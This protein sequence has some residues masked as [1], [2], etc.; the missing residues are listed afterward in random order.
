[1]NEQN[2]LAIITGATGGLGK[3]F[4]IQLA[5]QKYNL[6]LSGRQEDKL[7]EIAGQLEHKF[8]I[9]AEPLIADLSNPEGIKILTDKIETTE[10]IDMLVSNAGYGERNKFNDEQVDDVMKMLSVH[11]NATVQL[12][13]KVLPAMI[14]AKC[15][16]IISVSS[17]SAFVPAPGSSVY[18]SSKLFL[19]SFMESIHMEVSRLGIKV[20]SLCPGLVHTGFHNGSAVEHAVE[21]RGFSLWMQP[22]EVVYASLRGLDRGKV[23]CVPGSIN[24]LIRGILRIAPRRP[25]YAVAKMVA[26]RFK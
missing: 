3:A 13:H 21:T 12:V 9:K 8:A 16:N 4:A 1:M 23:I 20:Q 7:R 19:N 15:G 17:L 22:E 11:V 18:S 14:K 5:R 25:Y 2:R 6:I 10:R 24:K 26:R